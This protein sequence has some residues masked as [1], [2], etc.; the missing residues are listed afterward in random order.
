[1][2]LNLTLLPLFFATEFRPQTTT[3]RMQT[4]FSKSAGAQGIRAE[5]LCS[6]SVL[7]IATARSKQAEHIVLRCVATNHKLV[8]FDFSGRAVLG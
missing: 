2:G 5:V 3:H 8:K 4:A 7:A 6:G 1:M